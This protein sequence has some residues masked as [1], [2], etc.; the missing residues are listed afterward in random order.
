MKRLMA[1]GSSTNER[2]TRRLEAT[3]GD[4]GEEVLDGVEPRAGGGGEVG[5]E[6][7]MAGQPD[8]TLRYMGG[9][10]VD[11]D[12]D[13]FAGGRLGFRS[14]GKADELLMGAACSGR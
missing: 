1:L 5:D 8:L 3:L 14:V 10:I 13:Q 12:V 11:N 9:V 7:R 4:L 2:K 6:A